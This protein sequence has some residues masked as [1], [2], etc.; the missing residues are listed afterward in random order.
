MCRVSQPGTCIPERQS[1]LATLV[2]LSLPFR[3]RL[4][5]GLLA[6]LL[7][8]CGSGTNSSDQASG[9]G[10]GQRGPTPV[11]YVVVQ[12]GAAPIQQELPGRIAAYQVSEVRPQVTGVILR[13]LFRE[14][15]M[16]NQ[17]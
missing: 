10:G 1:K 6:I 8:A 2:I 17:G 16:V 9:R 15:A 3:R 12:Q 11:G 13:R 4:A 7:A 14:G 5:V